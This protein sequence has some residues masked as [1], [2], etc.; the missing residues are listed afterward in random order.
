MIEYQLRH[1]KRLDLEFDVYRLNSLNSSVR[2]QG[3][4]GS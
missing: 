3:G 2:S 1:V 4:K